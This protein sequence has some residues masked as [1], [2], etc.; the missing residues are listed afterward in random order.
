MKK[1]GM[2]ILLDVYLY[3][4]EKLLVYIDN[5]KNKYQGIIKEKEYFFLIEILSFFILFGVNYFNDKRK[6]NNYN[7]VENVIYKEEV[8]FLILIDEDE[9]WIGVFIGNYDVGGY[10]ISFELDFYFLMNKNVNIVKKII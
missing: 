2:I 6:I 3:G 9:I 7:W 8:I 10:I 1:K 5:K 4:L